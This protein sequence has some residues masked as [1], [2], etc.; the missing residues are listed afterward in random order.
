[1]QIPVNM[2]LLGPEIKQIS[3]PIEGERKKK[4]SPIVLK[5]PQ[6]FELLFGRRALRTS[7]KVIDCEILDSVDEQRRET[8]ILAEK[9]DSRSVSP[10]QLGK[11]FLEFLEKFPEMEQR[12]LARSIFVSEGIIHIQKRLATKL[13]ENLQDMV[14]QGKLS[15]SVASRVV[16]LD[17]QQQQREIADLFFAGK[18]KKAA[19]VQRLV[20]LVKKNPSDSIEVLIK[21]LEENPN[22]QKQDSSEEGEWQPPVRDKPSLGFDLIVVGNEILR[23]ATDLDLINQRGNLIPEYQRLTFDSKLKALEHRLIILRETLRQPILSY[24]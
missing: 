13:D 9:Y 17:N 18:L 3:E 5:I 16:A 2:I 24:A 10:V 6:G 21:R 20:Q 8:L 22:G 4:K 11:D 23:L 14:T 1:M 12:Q 7:K 19:D 15:Y